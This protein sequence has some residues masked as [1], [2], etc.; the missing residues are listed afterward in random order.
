MKREPGA[1]TV[2]GSAG[3][4][5]TNVAGINR[6]VWS[7]RED[8]V[9]QWMG[10]A[11]PEYRGPQIGVAVAPGTY[12]ARIVL[13]GRTYEQRFKVAADPR[14]PYTQADFVAAYRFAK[15]NLNLAGAINVTLNHLDD[16]K[17][18]LVAAQKGA[19][20]DLAS[21]IGEALKERDAIFSLFTADY[22]NDED[23]IQ[24]PGG[25]R[26]DAPGGF[27]AAAPPTQAQLDYGARY[28]KEY[29]IAIARYKAYIA[30]YLVPLAKAG[31][32]TSW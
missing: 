7:F 20:T 26:E 16:Q 11:R 31:V 8:G 17:R 23:S 30:K 12:T 32:K 2:R 28:Q 1:D 14:T 9:P 22:H 19:G 25:L 3:P 18:A 21:N 27:G 10:A 5:V 6:V 29:A 15:K 13:G 24:R 4:G